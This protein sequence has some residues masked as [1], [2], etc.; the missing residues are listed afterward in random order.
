[1]IRCIFLKINSSLSLTPLKLNAATFL[2][3]WF[4]SGV[5][6]LLIT[7]LIETQKN[8]NYN[9]RVS[10]SLIQLGVDTLILWEKCFS[11]VGH[12]QRFIPF[13]GTFCIFFTRQYPDFSFELYVFEKY[14]LNFAAIFA[15][16]KKIVAS[17]LSSCCK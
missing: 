15:N 8:K 9:S 7:F 14:S 16:Y 1:M 2:W 17:L 12:T 13:G 4:S 3:E 5:F 11:I 6:S 10:I